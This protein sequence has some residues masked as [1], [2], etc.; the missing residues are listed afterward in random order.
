MALLTTYSCVE[1]FSSSKVISNQKGTNF[2]SKSTENVFLN[3]S[4]KSGH[5]DPMFYLVSFQEKVT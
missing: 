3:V 2:D 1:T 5:R 4:Y